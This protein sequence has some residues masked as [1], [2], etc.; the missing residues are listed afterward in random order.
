MI[1]KLI[2]YNFINKCQ[3]HNKSITGSYNVFFVLLVN[4]NLIVQGHTPGY[5]K[6]FFDTTFDTDSDECQTTTHFCLKII[7]H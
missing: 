7:N 6:T 2:L 3:L 5:S 4:M 1:S